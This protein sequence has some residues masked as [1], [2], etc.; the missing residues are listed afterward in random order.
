MNYKVIVSGHLEF[1]NSRS[2][3][4]MFQSY[5]QRLETYYKQDVF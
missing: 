1:G 5:K 4:K 3:E 2:Y